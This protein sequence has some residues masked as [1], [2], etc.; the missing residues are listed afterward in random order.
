[1]VVTYEDSDDPQIAVA[2]AGSDESSCRMWVR[3]HEEYLM[4]PSP[5]GQ[6][7]LFYLSNGGTIL[8]EGQPWW[9]ARD[10]REAAQQMRIWIDKQ[11]SIGRL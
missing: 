8:C 5:S 11:E 2:P 10:I 4:A 6:W 7:T 3:S 9:F 1:M